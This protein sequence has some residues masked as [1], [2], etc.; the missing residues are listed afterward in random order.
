MMRL[1]PALVMAL[2]VAVGGPHTSSQATAA[3]PAPG[4]ERS[5]E[6]AYQALAPL[7]LL[8]TRS[9][10]G[11][12]TR[13]PAP[14]GSST[15][16][17][18]AGRGG[19]PTTGVRAVVLNVTVTQPATGGFVTAYPGGTS[20][21]GTSSLNFATGW[22]RANLVTVKVGSDG[23]VNLHTSTRTHLIA[24]LVGVYLSS[25]ST[26]TA[27]VF[28]GY[29]AVEPD[30]VVDTRDGT[31]GGPLKGRYQLVQALD[32]GEFLSPTI[33]AVVVNVTATNPEAAGYL[34]AFDGDSAMPT[35]ST[36]NFAQGTTVPNMAVIPTSTCIKC[37]DDGR[38]IPM[39]A[40]FNGSARSTDVIV[41]IVG[42]IDDDTTGQGSRFRPLD[43]V[44]IVDSRTSLRATA[45]DWNHQQTVALPAPLITRSTRAIVANTTLVRPTRSTYLTVW[46]DGS[47]QPPVSNLN[48]RA[49]QTVANMTIS[50]TAIADVP[51]ASFT[52]FNQACCT[53]VVMDLVGTME[54]FPTTFADTDTA[55]RAS[56]ADTPQGT[57]ATD[58]PP[59]LSA[60]PTGEVSSGN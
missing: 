42:F 20:L 15:P 18:I 12:A 17:M 47:F 26:P 19:A 41:D 43:P 50:G 57:A 25:A 24:D 8:D 23:M 4:S 40:I 46:S 39:F 55:G 33:R 14:A 29:V 21:P 35:T 59:S 54:E 2:A 7:R 60:L 16:V 58:A 22:T 36:L 11:V 38:D 49:G 10:L 13:T 30:R 44:R 1:G 27:G 37:A 32:Y 5:A 3:L 28:G 56:T 48:A 45:F 51:L 9:A 6:G 34:T 31:W 53:D 52:V